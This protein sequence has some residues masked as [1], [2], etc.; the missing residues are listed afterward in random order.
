VPYNQIR[1]LP[2]RAFDHCRHAANWC[3]ISHSKKVENLRYAV[4]LF[5]AHFKCCRVHSAFGRTSAQVAGLTDL[6]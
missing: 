4:S 5:V 1:A 6:G 3:T 2:R